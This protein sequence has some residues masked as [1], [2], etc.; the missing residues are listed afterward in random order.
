MIGDINSCGYVMAHSCSTRVY[1][2]GY[3]SRDAVATHKDTHAYTQVKKRRW[4]LFAR[5]LSVVSSVQR[6]RLGL[7]ALKMKTGH[8]LKSRAARDG[9]I[10]SHNGHVDGGLHHT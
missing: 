5:L 10:A 2:T 9:S 8:V 1:V 7:A 3:L 4:R 6:Y